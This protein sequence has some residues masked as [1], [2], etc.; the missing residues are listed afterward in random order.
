MTQGFAAS[1]DRLDGMQLISV[2]F[3]AVVCSKFSL[4]SESAFPTIILSCAKC[5]ARKSQIV[6]K[7]AAQPSGLILRAALKAIA[8]AR[9]RYT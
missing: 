1:H 2:G 8:D 6:R 4:L 9:L 7:P 5:V 3:G